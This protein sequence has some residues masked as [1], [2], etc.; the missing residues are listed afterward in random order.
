[1][2]NSLFIKKTHAMKH[3][4]KLW[5]SF[6][7]IV[8]AGIF[9]RLAFMYIQETIGVVFILVATACMAVAIIVFAVYFKK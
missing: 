9:A 2:V 4:N 1:M 6:A 7:G 8:L 5:I 3:R